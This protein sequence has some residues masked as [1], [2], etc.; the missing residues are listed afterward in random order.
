MDLAGAVQPKLTLTNIQPA[1]TGGYS[2]V[3]SY[4]AGAVISD[5]A[6]IQIGPAIFTRITTGPGAGAGG[7]RPGAWADFDGDGDL[8][9]F[10]AIADRQPDTLFANNG[11]GTFTRITDPVLAR[12]AGQSSAAQWGDY[13]NEG[14]LDLFVANGGWFAADLEEDRPFTTSG[15]TLGM[16]ILVVEDEQ[17]LLRSLA[18]ALR[19]EGYA[20]DTAEDGEE[21]LFRAETSDYDALVLDVMLPGIDGWELL[22][23]LRQ[24]KPTPVLMLTARDATQD[25]VRGLPP[26]GQPGGPTP[27]E[28]GRDGPPPRRP[29]PEFRGPRGRFDGPPESREIR[30]RPATAIRR[31]CLARASHPDRGADLRNPDHPCPAA[32]SLGVPR[33]GRRLPANGPANAPTHP[34]SP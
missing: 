24:Q 5:T 26:F 30:L 29:G 22:A 27:F 31:R 8:D 6:R 21:G 4:L 15:E 3:L 10:R 18:K 23:R 34:V 19:E 17:R 1:A 12:D 32:N 25:R 9:L 16:R 11:D 33:D 7:D 14:W 13:D 2:V 20:V 28:P